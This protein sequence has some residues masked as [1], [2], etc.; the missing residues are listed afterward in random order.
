MQW[1]RR[2]R[3]WK[4]IKKICREDREKVRKKGEKL[5]RF[6]LNNESTCLDIASILNNNGDEKGRKAEAPVEQTRKHTS[7]KPVEEKSDP[8]QET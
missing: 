8:F 7:K 5:E 3:Q 6:L 4:I 2:A 1:N